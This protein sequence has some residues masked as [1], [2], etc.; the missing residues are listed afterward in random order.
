MCLKYLTVVDFGCWHGDGLM[1]LLLSWIPGLGGLTSIKL[2][3]GRHEC[4]EALRPLGI[5]FNLG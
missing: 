4:V 1:E 5:E 2:C 3:P